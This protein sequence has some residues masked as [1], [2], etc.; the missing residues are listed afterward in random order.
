VLSSIGY[1]FWHKSM[2]DGC[3]AIVFV[4]CIFTPLFRVNFHTTSKPWSRV[5]FQKTTVPELAKKFQDFH[6]TLRFITV[7]ITPRWTLFWT[8]WIQSIPSYI[9]SL[10]SILISSSH[11]CLYLWSGLFPSRFMTKMSYVLPTSPIGVIWPAHLI[12]LYLITLIIFGEDYR[13]I[14]VTRLCKRFIQIIREGF[15]LQ[16]CHKTNDLIFSY[17]SDLMHARSKKCRVNAVRRWTKPCFWDHKII[18]S[19][20]GASTPDFSPP[21]TRGWRLTQTLFWELGYTPRMYNGLTSSL[22]M[23]AQHSFPRHV[24]RNEGCF[25]TPYHRLGFHGFQWVK[26]KG[27]VVPVLI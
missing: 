23:K 22:K 26:G 5:L 15:F 24:C 7:P 3:N 10:G 16:K 21:R 25:T 18:T 17:R 13:E 14:C 12:L 11:L 8:T 4:I 9:N 6:G 1:R 20:V 2:T 19:R 27:K